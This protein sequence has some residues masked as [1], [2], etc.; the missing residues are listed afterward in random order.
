MTAEQ[1][2]RLAAIRSRQIEGAEA[3]HRAQANAR[4]AALR[5]VVAMVEATPSPTLGEASEMLR[6]VH[7]LALAA[8]V[9]SGGQR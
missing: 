9:M 1:A 4:G 2:G 3:A 5:A 6:D 8:L 7:A